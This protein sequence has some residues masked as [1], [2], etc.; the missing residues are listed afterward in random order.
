MHT[1][2]VG[3]AF[4]WIDWNV[5]KCEK[6]GVKPEDAEDV[7]NGA[8]RPYPEQIGHDKI[9]VRGKSRAGDY[10]QVIYLFERDDVVFVIHARRLTLRE[11]RQL[12]RRRR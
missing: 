4:R 10:L 12:R 6:H 1:L 8:T 7:V 2:V 3:Y 11:K 5:G 9:M